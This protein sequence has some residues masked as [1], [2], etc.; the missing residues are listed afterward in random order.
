MVDNEKWFAKTKKVD[1]Q[2]FVTSFYPEVHLK[3]FQ[4]MFYK[5]WVI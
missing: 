1:S 5:S 3:L 4:D 2:C